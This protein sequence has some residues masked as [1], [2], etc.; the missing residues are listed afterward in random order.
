MKYAVLIL[1][2]LRRNLRRTVLTLL[3]LMISFFLYCA[4]FTLIEGMNQRLTRQTADLNLIL[5]PRYMSTF[6]DAQLPSNYLQKIKSI[7]LVY[8]A[9]PY[10]IYLGNGRSQ[11][12]PVFVIGVDPQK[13]DKIRNLAL[14]S[15]EML[16]TFVQERRGALV[17]EVTMADNQ[18][19]VGDEIILKGIG[20][21]PPLALKIVGVMQNQGDY[22][23]ATLA[24]Y[25]YIKTLFDNGDMSIIFFRAEH[26]YEVPWLTRAAEQAFAA[27][28]VPVDVITEKAFIR[29]MI[30]ELAGV[31][32]AIQLVAWVAIAAT[33]AIV[34]NTLYMAIRERKVEIGVLRTLGFSQWILF[35]LFLGEAVVI[36]TAG[37]VLGSG[38]AWAIFHYADIRIP[39]GMGNA[40]MSITAQAEPVFQSILISLGVGIV[41]STVP[42][43]HYSSRPITENLSSVG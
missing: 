35:L 2:N 7:P 34:G 36:S 9:T 10:K 29:S 33:I 40:V 8:A 23:T 26:P 38:L 30:S 3:A 37:G 24:H 43:L 32:T 15:E 21:N 5:R 18:W 19:T 41:S 16:A 39:A 20:T 14:S 31:V 13:I 22:G 17:G 27:V 42:A 1:K 25:E 4:I 12:N 28:P 6:I 11:E